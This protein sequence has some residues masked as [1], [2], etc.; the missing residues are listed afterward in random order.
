MS[1]E[2]VPAPARTL[3]VTD[4]DSEPFWTGG[5]NGNLLIFRCAD[6]SYYV[7]PPVHFCPRCEGRKVAPQPVSGRGQV[8]SFTV[9]HKQW[10]PGLPVPYVLALVSI[11]EQDDVRL[12]TNIVNC[13]PEA[14]HVGMRVSVLFERQEEIAIP[15]FEPES[16]A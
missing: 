13:D 12:A 9:N 5:N 10:V 2:N 15:L 4:I 16:K 8:V 7:H 11:D 6:C 3:P 14:V 1:N